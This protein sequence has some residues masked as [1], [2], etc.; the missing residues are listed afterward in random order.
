MRGEKRRKIP[1]GAFLGSGAEGVQRIA[2]F[3]RWL[4]SPVTVGRTYLPG[5][6]WSTIEGTFAIL[7]PWSQWR[8]ADPGRM[9]VLNVP[10]IAPNEAGM[11][12]EIVAVM[13]RNG[14][15]GA[16]DRHFRTLAERLV[17]EGIGDTVLVPGWE[18]NGSTYSGR[19]GPDP[20]AWK[21]YW[22]RIVHTM[23]SVPGAAFRF[24]F[25]AARGTDAV[26]WTECYPGD[27][28]VDIIGSDSYDQPQGGTFDHYVQ[29]PLGLRDQAV[30]AAVRGK[31]LSIPEWGLFRNSDNPDYIRG[32]YHW[33]VQNNVMYQSIADYCPH[34]VWQCPDNPR[35]AAV[36]RELFGGNTTTEQNPPSP[37]QPPSDTPPASAPP[38]P[39]PADPAPPA[40]A[41]PASAPASPAV[42]SASSPSVPETSNAPAAEAHTRPS[43]SMSPGR[44]SRRARASARAPGSS[45]GTSAPPPSGRISVRPGTPLHTRDRP[46]ARASSATSG[47]PSHRE[48]STTR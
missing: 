42:T 48:G 11:P 46:R 32:M 2:A 44:D 27:D 17:L 9:L 3:E 14:A 43:S 5:E 26:P 35:S 12:D 29:E 41:P 24:D 23:R 15:S 34:G 8:R 7:R 16:Y 19:C 6:Q 10:I 31:P 38:V 45:G 47:S 33:M 18:M 22:R 28:V 25:T 37:D 20:V 1:L 30:F 36:Y 13:L 4:G 39:A 40:P 21:A